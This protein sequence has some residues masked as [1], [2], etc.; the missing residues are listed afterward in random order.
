MRP[1]T[2][3][4]VSLPCRSQRWAVRLL[5][6]P[7]GTLDQIH[8]EAQGVRSAIPRERFCGGGLMAACVFRGGGEPSLASVAG[9]GGPVAASFAVGVVGG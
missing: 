8:R 5:L 6:A 4:I 7:P 2:A 9:T 3:R 1:E